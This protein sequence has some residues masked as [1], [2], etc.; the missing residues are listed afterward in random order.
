MTPPAPV[1]A[2]QLAHSLAPFGSSR[3]LPRGSYLD[4]AVLAWER[5]YV[6]DGWRCL[7]RSSEIPTPG[8]LRAYSVGEYGVLLSRDREGTLHAF[9]NTCRHRGHELVPCGGSAEP[10]AIVCPYHAWTYNF[11]GSLLGAP[12]FRDAPNFDKSRLG[13]KAM[14]LREWHGWV[15]VDRSRCAPPFEQHIGALEAIVARYDAADLVVAVTHEYDVAANWKV[16]IENYQECYHCSMIH[17]EL[18]QVS[19]P[20]SGD[21]LEQD[22]DWV[23]GW[24]DLRS[25]ADTMSLDGRSGGVAMARLDEHERRTVMYIAVL[26]N[27][28]L[29]LH[30]DYVMT[31]LLTPL[32]PH[33]TRIQCSWAFPPEVAGR[34]D[35]DPAYAVDFWDLTNRQDWAACESVQRGMRA[36]GFEP[37][38][39]APE[40]DGVYDFV[41]HLARAYQ[42]SPGYS[43]SLSPPAPSP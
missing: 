35:F 4:E 2:E 5:Q 15:F 29:S 23:G 24:M 38:P 17:P 37:G 11:D 14:P 33:R 39:L 32:S 22:G 41:T 6:F 19:P 42:G 26:P 18:C 12:G 7:G 25:G 27:L 3:M 10:K 30:P 13:L 20:E 28:L 9:E 40:E 1:D 43:S 36:P 34:D 16:I 8:M 31:H 21:N